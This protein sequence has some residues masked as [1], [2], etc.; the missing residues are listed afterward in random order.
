VRQ[1]IGI[2]A[3]LVLIAY[4]VSAATHF[5]PFKNL[6]R[7]TTARPTQTVRT[8]PTTLTRGTPTPATL[9]EADW[10]HGADGWTLPPHWQITAGQLVNDGQGTSPIAVP[11]TVTAANYAIEMRVQVQSVTSATTCANTFG[12]LALDTSGGERYVAHATCLDAAPPFR[13]QA[14]LRAADDQTTTDAD[15]AAGTA[16]QIYRITV[17][18]DQISFAGEGGL[19]GNVTTKAPLSPARFAIEDQHVQLIVTSLSIV[20]LAPGTSV[21]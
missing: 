6:F 15:F 13:G 20:Q 4:G 17:Q 18:G 9:Y 10:T 1:A 21:G 5:D 3:V 7:P 12:L 19:L 16:P 2:L 14:E 8:T 11:A